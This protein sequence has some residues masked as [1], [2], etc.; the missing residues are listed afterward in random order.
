MSVFIPSIQCHWTRRQNSLFPT[1][2]C[3]L[4]D[5]QIFLIL[6]QIMLLK[7]ILVHVLVSVEVLNSN[8]QDNVSELS[9]QATLKST[10]RS[11]QRAATALAAKKGCCPVSVSCVCKANWDQA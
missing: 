3:D 7:N 1:H 10:A 5:E 11:R 6:V 9:K 4:H 8:A 2:S